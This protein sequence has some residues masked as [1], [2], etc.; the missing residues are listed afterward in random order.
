MHGGNATH[1]LTSQHPQHP[2]HP[3]YLHVLVEYVGRE[4]G[5][6]GAGPPCMLQ[7]QPQGPGVVVEGVEAVPLVIH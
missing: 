3:Q 1:S 6:W 7:V 4:Q 5:T 2:Q